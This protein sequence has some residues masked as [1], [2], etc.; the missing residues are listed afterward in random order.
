MSAGDPPHV[1]VDHG[2]ES[3]ERL[4]VAFFPRDEQRADVLRSVVGHDRCPPDLSESPMRRQI[5]LR[6]RFALT[7]FV[8]LIVPA[9][10][11]YAQHGGGAAGSVVFFSA[12]EDHANNQ[13]Y[14]M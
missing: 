1:R 14:V 8:L 9:F 7:M 11:A 12:R 5:M 10:H 2:H 4:V 3:F 6:S 13:I